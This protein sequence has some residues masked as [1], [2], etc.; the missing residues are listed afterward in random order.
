MYHSNTAV[1]FVSSVEEADPSVGFLNI[2]DPQHVPPS[3]GVDK[4]A[5]VLNTLAGALPYHEI[6]MVPRPLNARHGPPREGGWGLHF[7]V[8]SSRPVED[9]RLSCAFPCRADGYYTI[10]SPEKIIWMHPYHA[11]RVG[12]MRWEE[13]PDCKACFAAEEV[14]GHDRAP[15]HYVGRPL[16]HALATE[17]RRGKVEAVRKVVDCEDLVGCILSFLDEMPVLMTAP[18]K[19]D[20]GMFAESFDF[21]RLQDVDEDELDVTLKLGENP[22]DDKCAICLDAHDHRSVQTSC[23]H[24]FHRNC[25]DEWLGVRGT[26]PT[27]R[28]EVSGLQSPGIPEITSLPKY[29]PEH[30][31]WYEYEGHRFPDGHRRL[32]LLWPPR[33]SLQLMRDTNP[34]YRP[35]VTCT[36]PFHVDDEAAAAHFRE[37]QRAQP[38]ARKAPLVNGEAVIPKEDLCYPQWPIRVYAGWKCA[39]Y[40]TNK[41]EQCRVCHRWH[42]SFYGDCH[43]EAMCRHKQFSPEACNRPIGCV[44]RAFCPRH[45]PTLRGDM[46][47]HAVEFREAAERTRKRRRWELQQATPPELPPEYGMRDSDYQCHC[48]HWL[49][50]GPVWPEG[51]AAGCTPSRLR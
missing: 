20:V 16:W 33:R 45:D 24:S 43:L 1:A 32:V 21:L 29:L 44:G 41:L 23:G 48:K 12:R 40:R 42:D 14:C 4:A 15:G 7:T 5:A 27:C 30:Y 36:Q 17:L 47:A 26:C 35:Y 11:L 22:D 19:C 2:N 31:E 18:L 38:P 50:E 10:R 6:E 28:G 9:S 37:A 13:C 51:H 39:V 34:E 49:G 25:I 3:P 8:F 46:K